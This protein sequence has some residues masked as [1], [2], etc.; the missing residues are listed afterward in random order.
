M[1]APKIEERVFLLPDEDKWVCVCG[2]DAWRV[3]C[4][5]EC[6]S[7]CVPA[8]AERRAGGGQEAWWWITV[9]RVRRF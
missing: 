9:L 2:R 7:T 5:R 6:V 8:A 3:L 4:G 1:N